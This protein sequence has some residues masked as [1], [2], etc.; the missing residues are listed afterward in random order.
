MKKEKTLSEIFDDAA[1]EIRDI[2]KVPDW[3]LEAAGVKRS[4]YD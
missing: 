2:T 3:L 1:K 4:D